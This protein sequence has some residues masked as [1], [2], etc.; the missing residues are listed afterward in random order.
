MWLELVQVLCMLSQSLWVHMCISSVV[1]EKS[2]ILEASTAFVLLQS[3]CLLDAPSLE[4]ECDNDIPF[5]AEYSKVQ[6]R[7]CLYVNLAATVARSF[8][9]EG[10]AVHWAMGT[11]MCREQAFYC[12]APVVEYFLVQVLDLLNSFGYV[13]HLMERAWKLISK[14]VWL[15][16]LHLYHYCTSGYILQTG[17][18]YSTQ[19]SELGGAGDYF[20]PLE[21]FKHLE[22]CLVRV[23]CLLEYQLDFS[24]FGDISMWW[25]QP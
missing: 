5:R 18:Y 12:Y 9:E 3:L 2:S 8:S 19:G 10:W 24:T 22:C 14:S 16:S 13:L 4:G 6:L 23:K 25:F 11:I 1:S 20:L 7:V 17:H 21:A 15:L